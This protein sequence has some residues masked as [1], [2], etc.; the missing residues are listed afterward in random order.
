ME[1]QNH[2]PLLD[3]N[4]RK[5]LLIYLHCQ[6]GHIAK[7]FQSNK[8]TR[9]NLFNAKKERFL[10]FLEPKMSLNCYVIW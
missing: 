2:F 3:N 6:I 4:T 10:H 8:N 9:A 5:L 1:M 7:S